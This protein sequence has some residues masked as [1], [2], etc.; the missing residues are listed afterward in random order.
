LKIICFGR[1]A[2]IEIQIVKTSKGC[3][4]LSNAHKGYPPSL[5]K[6]EH[7]LLSIALGKCILKSSLFYDI[8]ASQFILLIFAIFRI[9]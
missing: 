1:W 2:A 6:A 8:S 3:S 5:E 9:N 7:A 4:R